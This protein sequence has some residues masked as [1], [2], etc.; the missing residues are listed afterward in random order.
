[1]VLS[2]IILTATEETT[3]EA[4]W[5]YAKIRLITFSLKLA[6]RRSRLADT[7]IGEGVCIVVSGMLPKTFK[8]LK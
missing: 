2:C 1:M 3:P 7:L 4:T 8:Y 6:R 5:F